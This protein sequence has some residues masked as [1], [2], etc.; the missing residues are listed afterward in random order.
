MTGNKA[1][2]FIPSAVANELSEDCIAVPI[3]GTTVS[4]FLGNS[5]QL[6][7]SLSGENRIVHISARHAI[8][9]S[10][11]RFLSVVASNA[12][13]TPEPNLL[14]RLMKV[15]FSFTAFRGNRYQ[16]ALQQLTKMKGKGLSIC[17]YNFVRIT[18]K[19]KGQEQGLSNDEL[20]L[21][22]YGSREEW[23]LPM[24]ARRCLLQHQLRVAGSLSSIPSRLH[25]QRFAK[26]M[27]E[28][29]D[30]ILG[31]PDEEGKEGHDDQ[32]RWEQDLFLWRHAVG[33]YRLSTQERAYALAVSDL[34]E[35]SLSPF[36][37]IRQ[38]A[39]GVLGTLPQTLP[40]MRQAVNS[41]AISLLR[42]TIEAEEGA[43]QAESKENVLD[44]C[45]KPSVV[46]GVKPWDA[47]ICGCG[48]LALS[49]KWLT[50]WGMVRAGL[51]TLFSVR[52]LG[53]SWDS[54][55][56]QRSTMSVFAAAVSFMR[57]FA[58]LPVE[59]GKGWLRSTR[60]NLINDLLVLLLPS[61]SDDS[62]LL[63]VQ[64]L[65]S[66]MH[67]RYQLFA[68]AAIHRL[69]FTLDNVPATESLDWKRL[70]RVC[71]SAI[72]GNILPLQRVGLQV[73]TTLLA[74]HTKDSRLGTIASLFSDRSPHILIEQLQKELNTAGASSS[75]GT[76]TPTN[77]LEVLLNATVSLFSSGSSPDDTSNGSSA[78]SKL[79]GNIMS[80]NWSFGVED[81][82][83]LAPFPFVEFTNWD[84]LRWAH[85]WEAII[86]FSGRQFFSGCLQ[87]ALAMLK[88]KSHDSEPRLKNAAAI[89]S[90]A[91]RFLTF[92]TAKELKS[93]SSEE[94]HSFEQ[95]ILSSTAA[96]GSEL[97]SVW[98]EF[99]RALESCIAA[100]PSAETLGTWS[101]AIEGGTA[102]MPL[103]S[104]KPLC[105]FVLNKC[106]AELD[107]LGRQATSLSGASADVDME[108]EG[109]SSGAFSH[110]LHWVDFTGFLVGKVKEEIHSASILGGYKPQVFENVPT[111]LQSEGLSP[112]VPAPNCL[113][114][115][116]L[117][118]AWL[119][120]I[121][122]SASEMKNSWERSMNSLQPLAAQLRGLGSKLVTCLAHPFKTCRSYV[123]SCITA[124]LMAEV[125]PGSET[126]RAVAE[127][128][129]QDCLKVY[130]RSRDAAAE[131][132]KGN[133]TDTSSSA[134][135][136]AELVMSTVLHIIVSRTALAC[137]PHSAHFHH[138][139]LWMHARLLH[140]P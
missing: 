55:K 131:E 96:T 133:D 15:L 87:R 56:E 106:M 113:S 40:W 127:Q 104:I 77:F 50:R 114:E 123:G 85:W 32:P 46:S 65:P 54:D 80:K 31:E 25:E 79:L 110:S 21:T 130:Q 36:M 140:R 57:R 59:E 4:L 28:D 92:W 88:E 23:P 108:G 62:S 101:R 58:A 111:T 2:R 35:L 11:H 78:A 51:T 45:L 38:R 129:I 22:L 107:N 103:W 118:E 60:V 13:T 81:F 66:P 18:R 90:A 17:R 89:L 137:P 49:G 9:R 97:V 138:S 16:D 61:Y 119:A 95:A 26:P 10:I 69:L 42:R 24:L 33:H 109:S 52:N 72:A 132:R 5:Q 64:P 134:Q 6:P 3:A 20:R 75:S 105:T 116:H 98:Q 39:V 93:A 44:A 37:D 112:H 91:C 8:F 71:G 27:A 53:S 122:G 139:P 99:L 70:W 121:P 47:V 135:N 48:L 84:L 117:R 30:A 136:P 29:T 128:T 73:F 74:A 12:G 83:K 115:P 100:R 41:A 86:A 7:Q 14:K 76:S 126:G 120:S 124:Y 19:M 34:I 68:T 63:P 1:L 102:H 43:R 67:W 94:L 125:S 82:V